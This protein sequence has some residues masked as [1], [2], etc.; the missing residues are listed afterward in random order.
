MARILQ[1]E[2]SIKDTN[3]IAMTMISLENQCV[4]LELAN[5]DVG[6]FGGAWVV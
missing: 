3:K 5:R 1:A 4:N 2:K 6:F